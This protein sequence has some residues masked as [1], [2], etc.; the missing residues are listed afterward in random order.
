MK[1][2]NFY[3]NKIKVVMVVNFSMWANFQAKLNITTT[4]EKSVEADVPLPHCVK[5][6]I[7]QLHNLMTSERQKEGH[8]FNVDDCKPPPHAMRP[9]ST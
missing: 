5:Q 4:F 9:W 6:D 1:S 8:N 3:T 2:S 7:H